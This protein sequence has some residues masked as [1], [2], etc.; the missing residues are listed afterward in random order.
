MI[1]NLN[2]YFLFILLSILMGFFIYIYS[3][4]KQKY[5][6]HFESNVLSRAM[7]IFDS[8]LKEISQNVREELQKFETTLKNN[9]VIVVD[10]DGKSLSIDLD[11]DNWNSL[12]W[13]NFLN[14]FKAEI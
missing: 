12:Q 6:E 10:N 8:R 7:T 4:K 2:K 11:D 14:N 3:C 1:C 9:T 5:T 13:T